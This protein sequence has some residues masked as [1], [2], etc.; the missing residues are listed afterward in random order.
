M[1]N[2]HYNIFFTS[3][4]DGTGKSFRLS[5]TSLI[6]GA[7]L[8]LCMIVFSYIGINRSIGSDSITYELDLLRKYKYITSNLLIES[9]LREGVVS[10]DDL[11]QI[12]I[13]YI[14][15]HNIIHPSS[16]P[17]EG[18]VTKGLYKDDKDIIHAGLN[19]AS[20]SKDQVISPLDGIV[21]VA[22][23][24]GESSYSVILHHQ[25]NFFTIYKNLDTLFVE[26]R[27]LV[28]KGQPFA[29]VCNI[30]GNGSHLHF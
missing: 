24:N 9:G 26:P 23:N 3:E 1:K 11:E 19:I 10:S 2:K 16:P 25:N 6:L 20:K 12:I 29:K 5:Q 28:L 27:D 8:C 18:Y 21:V 22:N 7:L 17:I 4:K 15:A 30:G 14:I 13:D